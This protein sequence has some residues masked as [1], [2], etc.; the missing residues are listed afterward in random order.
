M[1]LK[2]GFFIVWG[3]VL[4][5]NLFIAFNLFAAEKNISRTVAGISLLMSTRDV[6]SN[7]QMEEKPYGTVMLMRKYGFG[8]P[9]EQSKINKMIGKKR[10]SLT[11]N[12]PTGVE[13]MD[14]LFFK[15]VLYRIDLHYGK[16]Y[17]QKVSWDVFTLSAFK[18]YGQPMVNNNIKQGSFAYRWSDGKT[19]LEVAKAGNLTSDKNQFDATVYNVFYTDIATFD[20]LQ[21]EEQSK[22]KD[23]QLAPKF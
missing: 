21:K 4:I 20:A 23:V 5:L 11:G 2:G 13:S 18:T 12:L 15:E 9:E 10:F 7:F 3:H 22:K 19:N 1:N 17:V 6:S 8:N 16:D 14:V